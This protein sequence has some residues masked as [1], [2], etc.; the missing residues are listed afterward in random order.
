MNIFNKSQSE[1]QDHKEFLLHLLWV[2]V[3]S[4]LV[5]GASAQDIKPFSEQIEERIF[6]LNTEKGYM[7]TDTSLSHA[8]R[9]RPE[10]INSLRKGK[11]HLSDNKM[12]SKLCYQL[13][14]TFRIVYIRGVR[15]IILVPNEAKPHEVYNKASGSV[16]F[17]KF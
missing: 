4:F 10:T 12:L 6:H 1:K 13:A 14:C 11:V 3:F 16:E 8:M 2:L 9:L 15:T 5:V 7:I 17:L